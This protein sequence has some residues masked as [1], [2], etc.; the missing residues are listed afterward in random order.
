[1]YLVDTNVISAGAPARAGAFPALVDWMDRQSDRLYLSV[2][3]IAEIEDGIAKARRQGAANKAA[4]LGE[5]FELVQH[6]YSDRILPFDIAAAR[7]A[8]Q[9]SDRARGAGLAPGFVDLMIAATAQAHGLSILTRNLK[10]F[11]PLG[12]VA[13]DPFDTIPR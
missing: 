6:L 7:F 9:L 8:G 13:H 12:V 1:M 4:S 2:A 3:T 11:L 10:H 5:W